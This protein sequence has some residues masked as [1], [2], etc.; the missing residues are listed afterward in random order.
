MI[1]VSHIFN[2]RH[3]NKTFYRSVSWPQ[4]FFVQFSAIPFEFHTKE[5]WCS[6]M[7]IRL[8]NCK[9][10]PMKQT[11]AGTHC[12][13]RWRQYATLTMSDAL[14]SARNSH[15][16]VDAHQVQR[17]NFKLNIKI[18]CGARRMQ[19]NWSTTRK[20]EDVVWSIWTGADISVYCSCKPQI[21]NEFKFD[22]FNADT[23]VGDGWMDEWLCVLSRAVKTT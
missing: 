15:V 3:L 6:M 19:I 1:H 18:V 20:T 5:M 17:F 23:Y 22:L 4:I 2:S 13:C 21:W 9:W 14:L 8:T 10:S 11:R 16:D 7:C 12:E